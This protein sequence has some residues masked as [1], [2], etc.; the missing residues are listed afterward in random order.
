MDHILIPLAGLVV[1]GRG[2]GW[3]VRTCAVRGRKLLLDPV[4]GASIL[5]VAGYILFMTYQNHPQPRY[6][7]VVAFF[8][9]FLS[10]RGRRRCS[11]A[12]RRGLRQ[13]GW[14]C[15]WLRDRRCGGGL[16]RRLRP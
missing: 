9:F 4:F 14:A 1:S 3:P 16:Q 5:A 12:D 15:G 2:S 11:A 13:L 10:R 6:F 8:C 7:A